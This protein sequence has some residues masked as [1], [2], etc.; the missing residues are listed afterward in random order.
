MVPLFLRVLVFAGVVY[1]LYLALRPKWDFTVVVNRQRCRLRG[2]FPEAQRHE[3]YTFL[4]DR[5]EFRGTVRI[6]GRKRPGGYLAL[7]IRGPLD[8]GSKQ[9]IRNFLV[10]RL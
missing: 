6:R 5:V 2:A 7:R 10:N 4:R 3:L 9:R 8:E 1:A